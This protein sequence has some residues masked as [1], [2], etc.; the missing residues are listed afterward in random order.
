MKNSLQ[1]QSVAKLVGALFII[2][3]VAGVLSFVFA[4]NIFSDIATV[5]TISAN[6]LRIVTG[7]IFILVMA[8][9]LS[10]VPV[11]LYPLIKKTHPRLALGSV[12]FRGALEVTIHIIAAVVWLLLVWLVDYDQLNLIKEPNTFLMIKHV[13]QTLNAVNSQMVSLVFSIGTFMMYYCLYKTKLLP[14]WLSLWGVYG[15]ILYF[16]CPVLYLYSFDFGILMLPLAIQEMV[17]GFWLI[18]KGFNKTV[19]TE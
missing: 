18:F 16:S 5:T 12:V 6:R 1:N 14:T 2:G 7:A 17:M 15:A 4:G 19:I 9:S 10:M 13:L 11:V 8:F 3:S